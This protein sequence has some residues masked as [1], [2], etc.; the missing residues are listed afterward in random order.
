[1]R[2]DVRVL[3]EI[4]KRVV[5]LLANIMSTNL[6]SLSESEEILCNLREIGVL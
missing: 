5:F 2:D 3:V 1:M 4:R 6:L